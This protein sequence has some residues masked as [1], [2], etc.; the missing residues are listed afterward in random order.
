MGKNYC[1]KKYDWLLLL[2]TKDILYFQNLL[3]RLGLKCF[4]YSSYCLFL[5][6]YFL[7]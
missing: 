5:E 3:N 6:R 1:L 7:G 4:A 2:R